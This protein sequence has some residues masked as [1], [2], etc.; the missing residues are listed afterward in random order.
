MMNSF[1]KFQLNSR[2]MYRNSSMKEE[3]GGRFF[4]N[5][6]SEEIVQKAIICKNYRG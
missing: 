1:T 3:G 2:R 5:K 6:T 4:C